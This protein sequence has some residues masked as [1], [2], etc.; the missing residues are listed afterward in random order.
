[1][2][3]GCWYLDCAKGYCP[4]EEE[5]KK[6]ANDALDSIGLGSGLGTVGGAE[7]DHDEE[8][9]SLLSEKEKNKVLAKRKEADRATLK[10]EKEVAKKKEKTKRAAEKAKKVQDKNAEK[11]VGKSL[12]TL[13]GISITSP[14]S[15]SRKRDATL[16]G[17]SF[18]TLQQDT[19]LLV[20]VS[21][22]PSIVVDEF[23]MQG[24]LLTL[25]AHFNKHSN[26]PKEWTD[27]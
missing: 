12:S 25:V 21:T 13:E 20:N 3:G 5:A 16:A 23:F 22:S 6:S 4:V 9:L 27:L 1:L 10:K 8:D 24:S 19:S 15:Q 2:K 14:P 18:S 26:F 17:L 7:D 11:V